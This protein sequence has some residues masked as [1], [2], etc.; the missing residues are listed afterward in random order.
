MKLWPTRSALTIRSSAIRQ[1]LFEFVETLLR[2][3][4][5]E[6]KGMKPSD[7]AD[8]QAENDGLRSAQVNQVAG[9]NQSSADDIRQQSA[10]RPF[11]IGLIEQFLQ[12]RA[13]TSMLRQQDCSAREL[14][15]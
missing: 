8:Q 5:H 4:E 13:S 3:Y 1:A 14:A 7:R 9:N 12:A 2:A 10:R 11:Q 6:A 15:C